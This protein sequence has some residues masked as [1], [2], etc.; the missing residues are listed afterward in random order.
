MA[1]P[2]DQFDT[3][4][5]NPFDQFDEQPKK[6]NPLVQFGKDT[7]GTVAGLADVV[8]GIPKAAV[9]TAAAGLAKASGRGGDYNLDELRDAAGVA[10]DQA[11]PSVGSIGGPEGI[12]T[13]PGYKAVMGLASLPGEGINWL[14]NQVGKLTD[15]KEAAGLTKLGLDVASFGVAIPGTKLAGKGLRKFAE[16]VDPVLRDAG[17]PKKGADLSA[18]HEEL[19]AP[20]VAKNPFDQFDDL[21][22]TEGHD[23]QRALFDI[24]EEGRMPNP[25]EAVPGDWRVDENGIPIKADLSMDAQNAQTPLQR[26]LWGDE[27]AQKHPQ[28]NALNLPQAIDSM[29]WAHRRGAIKK[30][31]LKHE[32]EAPGELEAA[33][34][35]ADIEA[36]TGD[37]ITFEGP[38]IP[39]NFKKQGG[40]VLVENRVK[41]EIRKV[42]DGFEAYVD[43]ERVGYLRSNL[44]GEQ[45]A[46]IGENA[47]V[48]IVKVD[49]AVKGKGVGSALYKAWVDDHKNNVAPSGKTSKEAWSLWQNKYPEK[50]EAFVKQEAA[51]IQDGAP[52]DQVLSNITDPTIAQRVVDAAAS[53]SKVPFN[54]RKQGGG[55]KLD[56]SK[57]KEQEVFKDNPALKGMIGDLLPDNRPVEQFLKEEAKAPDLDQNSLQKLS[58]YLT[59]G[60]VYQAIKT[61]NPLIKRVSDRVL[62]A[63]NSAKGRI[64]DMIHDKLAPAARDLSKQEKA[65]IWAAQQ[66]AEKTK[67]PLTREVLERNGFNEKQINWMGTHTDVMRAMFDKMNEA[68]KAT[69][70]KPVSAQIAYLASRASGD[71][72][73][74]IYKEVNGER[75]PVSILG[76]NTRRGLNADVKKLQDAHPEWIV[77]EE[78]FFGGSS[79]KGGTAEGFS[80]MLD[81]LAK[82]NP[83]VALLSEHINEILTKD[84]FNYMNAKSHTMAKK[85]ISGMQGRKEF[86]DAVTNAEEGMKA[87][88]QYA[89]KMIQWAEMSK[90]IADLKPILDKDN[91]LNMPKAKEWSEQYIQQALGNNPTAVGRAIDNV[92]AETFKAA[93]YGPNAVGKIPQV[94]KRFANGILLGFGNIG[95]MAANLLQPF[96]STP[97]MMAF[98]KA[99]GLEKSFDAGTGYRYLGDAIVTAFRDASGQAVKPYQKEALQYAREKHVYSS[100]LFDSNNSVTKGVGHY[101]DKG[102]QFGSNS[103]EMRTRQIAYLSYVDLLHENGLSAKEGLYQVAQKLT[104]IQMNNYSMSEAPKAYAAMGGIGKTAYNLMSFKHNEYSR[105]AML[106]NEIGRSKSGAPIAV[107]LMSQVAFAGVMG[108]ILYSEADFL[109]KQISKQL[110]KPT[111]LT[112]VLLD[113]PDISDKLKYGF[114]STLGVDMTSRI[115]TGPLAPQHVSDAIMPGAGKLINMGSAVASAVTS[116]SEYNAKN[117]VREILPNSMTGVADRAFFSKPGANGEEQSWN[118]TKVIPNATRNDADKLWKTLG[119]TGM[120]EAKQKSREYEND[121]IT[122]VYTDI[123]KGL[124]DKA[125]KEFMMKGAFPND[126]ATKYIQAQGDPKSIERELTNIAVE[127]SM[128]AHTLGI[129]KNAMSNSITSTHK[130][131]RAV[132][133]E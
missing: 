27:L 54:F 132:G 29:D 74:L 3:A 127:Q 22:A 116:P 133:Q 71:F 35:Q 68:M 91:G 9:T 14:G 59:K 62:E 101:W 131:M 28:E 16:T 12:S 33:K 10:V 96:K 67:K 43:G 113:N 26:N 80:Q 8:T 82:N 108:T 40:G 61:Q 5:A 98:L 114:G 65:D 92:F 34:M 42:A 72:R 55:I 117:A 2:F 66:I 25:Y 21:K 41:P 104:D 70:E 105:M 7:L 53:P 6:S 93:G 46:R 119:M 88:V 100:D 57:K 126:F 64:S 52:R 122:R 60:S 11:V 83:D 129:L 31:Q 50:V 18:L 45:S 109:V 49:D 128:D 102:V 44:T 76:A 106:A 79:K 56:Y 13:N 37:K 87:Q 32:M 95:F 75:T 90:A 73:R 85:G 78:R 1:N 118:R 123:R 69:G 77:G 15:S 89:E 120:N 97:E 124:V 84:A 17:K 63:V 48:D 103:I 94:A 39:F 23:G 121:S 112:K 38:S 58:N 130:L 107:N 125:S 111:S 4:E 36:A 86:V 19:K 47:N 99:R 115:G 51:R 30:T 24:P 110:G 20:E 81:L